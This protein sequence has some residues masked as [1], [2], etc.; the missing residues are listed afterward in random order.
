MP[1]GIGENRD[2]R[3]D[4]E[5][6]SFR[7]RRIGLW[8]R[9][10]QRGIRGRDIAAAAV[11]L[12][13]RIGIEAKEIS[14]SANESGRVGRAREPVKMPFFDGI[15]IDVANPQHLADLL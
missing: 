7:D 15:E 9:E 8:R 6:G 14:V 3:R 12:D 13:D 11:L 10:V 1:S 2:Q 5:E 4:D